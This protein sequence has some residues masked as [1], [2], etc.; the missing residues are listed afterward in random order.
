[1]GSTL[2]PGGS[3]APSSL[4]S[5]LLT[6]RGRLSVALSLPH[7]SLRRRQR[8]VATADADAMRRRAGGWESAPGERRTDGEVTQEFRVGRPSVRIC[9]W[10]R[11]LPVFVTE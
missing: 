3:F 6:G 9:S 1:M 4:S 8:G 11:R 5:A 7:L 10:Q 2:N